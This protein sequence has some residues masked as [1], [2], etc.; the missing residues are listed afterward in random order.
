MCVCVRER[1]RE[2]ER[3]RDF[4]GGFDFLNFMTIQAI[5]HWLMISTCGFSRICIFFFL[6]LMHCTMTGEK[7]RTYYCVYLKNQNREKEVLKKNG[8]RKYYH[9]I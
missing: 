2:R 7:F 8:I 9:H 3:D 1:E 5:F 6:L 4:I